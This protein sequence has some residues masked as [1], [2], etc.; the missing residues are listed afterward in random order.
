MALLFLVQGLRPNEIVT[1]SLDR[2]QIL[3]PLFLLF[4]SVVCYV[5]ID[6]Q[7]PRCKIKF[8]YRR[9]CQNYI[10]NTFN[11]AINMILFFLLI[12]KEIESF[13]KRAFK[14]KS[15]S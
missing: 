9:C 10:G 3:L 12:S 13:A 14:H 4:Y 8:N 11:N 2:L 5:P 7:L 6:K 15:T 1:V